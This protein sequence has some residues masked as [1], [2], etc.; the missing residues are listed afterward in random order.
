MKA[1]LKDHPKQTLPRAKPMQH[2]ILEL[3]Q[4]LLDDDVVREPAALLLVE[5]VEDGTHQLSHTLESE[6]PLLKPEIGED[7][8][9][10][11][12]PGS[13]LRGLALGDVAC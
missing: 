12:G 9:A 3:L 6:L 8:P 2:R 7:F 10:D 1:Q 4:Q 11:A 13:L 5:L